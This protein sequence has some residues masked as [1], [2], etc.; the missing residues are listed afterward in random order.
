[1]ARESRHLAHLAGEPTPTRRDQIF[2][3]ALTDGSNPQ[4][5]P[6]NTDTV[7]HVGEP[8]L[9][10]GHE[11]GSH[12][13]T[14]SAEVA[15]HHK[16]P[17]TCIGHNIRQPNPSPALSPGKVGP[18]HRRP[19]TGHRRP[20][21]RLPGCRQR[22]RRSEKPTS[23]ISTPR[24]TAR[25]RRPPHPTVCRRPQRHRRS[26]VVGHRRNEQRHKGASATG[27]RPQAAELPTPEAPAGQSAH[28][29]PAGRH[30]ERSA[31]L[32][33]HLGPAATAGPAPI[34]PPNEDAPPWDPRSGHGNAGSG[35]PTTRQS[36]Q[37]PT[38]ASRT[39][40]L[41]RPRPPRSTG[42]RRKG[43][44]PPSL[45]PRGDPATRSGG[46]AA[47]LGGEGWRR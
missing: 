20:C 28:R 17:P 11:I 16:P 19:T 21:R 47:G 31:P 38:P 32:P 29:P 7:L 37:R 2:R 26:R 42:A 6:T 4:Q 30:P 24:L 5:S 9:H 40:G 13:S 35:Q 34:Q 41:R 14:R 36:G 46:G 27:R 15:N 10:L 33:Y 44:P 1:M 23:A 3:G 12:M 43:P 18:Q 25:R 45:R 22:P 39:N 8:L